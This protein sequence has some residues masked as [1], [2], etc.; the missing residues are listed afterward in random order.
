MSERF[1]SALDGEV[2]RLREENRA[3]DEQVKLLVQTDS[4][5]PLPELSG[6]SAD[7]TPL[8]PERCATCASAGPCSNRQ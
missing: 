7:Q 4:A 6:T 3:L 5:L 1:H 8:A 2:E